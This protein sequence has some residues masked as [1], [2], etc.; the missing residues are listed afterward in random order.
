MSRS[1]VTTSLYRT[2]HHFY[3]VDF[4]FSNVVFSFLHLVY[5]CS[6]FYNNAK[7]PPHSLTDCL[8]CTK[9]LRHIPESYAHETQTQH[10]ALDL[11]NPSVKV[12]KV[13]ITFQDG[14]SI[15]Y[16]AVFL[17]CTCPIFWPQARRRSS[18][19]GF[20]ENSIVG[21]DIFK[22]SFLKF[23]FISYRNK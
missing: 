17:N 12:W 23:R 6:L 19:F 18:D 16:G 11:I 5:T 3:S 7:Q 14:G 1:S 21:S 22:T 20:D 9:M 2:L 13:L 8:A 4:L 10:K 15:Q